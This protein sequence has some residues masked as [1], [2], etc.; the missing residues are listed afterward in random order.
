MFELFA[1][2]TTSNPTR[3]PR[4]K[5]Q[6]KINTEAQNNRHMAAEAFAEVAIVMEEAEDTEF[7]TGLCAATTQDMPPEAIN[8]VS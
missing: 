6:S 8:T 1:Q 7:L 4:P 5:L 3:N 2:S